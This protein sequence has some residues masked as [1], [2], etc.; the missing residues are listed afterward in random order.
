MLRRKLSK[1]LVSSEL[2]HRSLD[3][4]FISRVD[5]SFSVVQ[6]SARDMRGNCLET[7]LGPFLGYANRVVVDFRSRIDTKRNG[8]IGVELGVF[9]KQNTYERGEGRR[10]P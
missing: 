2:E 10:I 1:N 4:K 9:R 7:S 5:L 3:G 6:R 8:D